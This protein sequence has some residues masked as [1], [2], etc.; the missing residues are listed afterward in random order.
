[1]SEQQEIAQR[2]DH[3]RIALT[4]YFKQFHR[5]EHDQHGDPGFAPEQRAKFEKDAGAT[6]DHQ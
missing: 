2:D 1:M 6:G 3:H 4:L 5:H